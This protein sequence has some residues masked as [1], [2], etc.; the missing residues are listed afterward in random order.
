L[1]LTEARVSTPFFPER[2][3][4]APDRPI[5]RD[6]K[7]L[8]LRPPASIMRL[9]LHL[10]QRTI[11]LGALSLLAVTLAGCQSI[12]GTQS[13]TQVRFIHASPDA[14]ALDLY[15]NLPQSSAQSSQASLYN[16]AFGAV[17][18]YMLL[19]PGAYTHTASVAGTLQQLANVRGTFAAGAQYTV[20]AGNIAA[21]LQM[22][23]LKDQSTPA[24]AGQ[25][26]LRFLGQAT[27]TGPVDL[28]LLP[29]GANLSGQAPI[30]IG[31]G[32]GV[33]TGY[34]NVPAN[35]YSVVALPAGSPPTSAATPLLTG[36]Q[37]FYPAGSVRTIVLLDQ[38][39]LSAPALQ[40]I[41]ADDFDP[42]S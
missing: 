17:S 22:S 34:L 16:V 23:V 15:Q 5:H 38:Q 29:S 18:S 30:A 28:Y 36:S 20:L 3:G 42:A 21:N 4:S 32:F 6:R 13:V 37:A 7:L 11:R 9:N 33:N 31:V 24:P 2:S 41:T 1:V 10:A 8:Q 26:A 27:R 25:V 35:T 12:A 19:P 40:L 14:P 39:P